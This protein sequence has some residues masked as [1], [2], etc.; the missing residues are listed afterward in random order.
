MTG[1][2]PVRRRLVGS[3]LRR[4]RENVGYALEDAATVLE[5]DRSKIS[6]IETGQ[7]G[8]RPKELRELLTEY[9]VP[10]SEQA[11]LLGLARR[12]GQHGW[13]EQYANVLPETVID[14]V[15]MESTAAEIM[16]YE[17]QLVPDLLQTADYARAVA[18][19]QPGYSSDAQREDAVAAKSERQA[20]VLGGGAR[21]AVVIGEAALHQQV[22]GP[23]VMAAQLTHLA[24]LAGELPNV[25]VQVLPFA[26]GAHAAAG[27]GSMTLLRFAET[28]EI[29]VIHLAALSGGIS[30][31]GREE[32]ARYL[33]TFAQLRAAALPS[34]RS[35]HLIRTIARGYDR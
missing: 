30:L 19:A 20:A 8:I 27:C 7:R 2:P 21:L 28:P 14:Y 3:A 15:I 32:V 23:D 25:T 6:R 18:E 33:R 22:G 35:A 31:E 24:G 12:G 9:G 16:A 11:A 10:D 29:G 34:S 17:A 5:C 26:A 13:W 1:E 4:Y